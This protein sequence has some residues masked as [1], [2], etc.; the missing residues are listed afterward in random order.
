MHV[1]RPVV[2][3]INHDA[4]SV[5]SQNGR[6]II[7]LPYPNRLGSCDTRVRLYVRVTV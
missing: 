5:E 4:Q 1:S 3:R 7:I 2:V 6:H